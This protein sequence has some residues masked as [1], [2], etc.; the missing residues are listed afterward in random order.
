MPKSGHILTL[1]WFMPPLHIYIQQ[2]EE[3][4]F[5]T[6]TH[7]TLLIALQLVKRS[8]C[9]MWSVNNKYWLF[10][11]FDDR[12]SRRNLEINSVWF[13][14]SAVWMDM[15]AYVINHHIYTS[16]LNSRK[17]K[18]VDSLAS[19]VVIKLIRSQTL[20]LGSTVQICNEN[21][22]TSWLFTLFPLPCPVTHC[23]T[24]HVWT[25]FEHYCCTFKLF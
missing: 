11:P 17:Q 22:H 1:K 5:Q 14:L 18:D 23:N 3:Q 25:R 10:V 4:I 9:F 24:A 8:Y 7:T 12:T 16:L 13:R 15:I 19:S 6:L 20:S 2:S 21:T